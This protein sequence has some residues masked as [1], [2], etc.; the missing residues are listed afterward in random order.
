M[1]TTAPLPDDDTWF[2]PDMVGRRYILTP[3]TLYLD[4]VH[5]I[6]VQGLDYRRVTLR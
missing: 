1:N 4:D 6:S 5:Q 3:C 2:S